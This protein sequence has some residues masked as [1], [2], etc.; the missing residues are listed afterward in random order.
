MVIFRII[1]SAGEPV[2][3]F[4]LLLTSGGGYSPDRLPRGFFI[5]RQ[6][7]QRAPNMLT[8]YL[9]YTAMTRATELGFRLEPRPSSGPVH[10]VPA[11]FR[12]DLAT[13]HNLLRP[14]QTL[15]VEIECARRIED[16]LFRLNQ[17]P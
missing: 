10:F 5:D 6:R 13:V 17:P 9:D 7:N 8:Y 11:E 12:G 4:D 14:H 15:L 16:R 3:D 2:P 1:D